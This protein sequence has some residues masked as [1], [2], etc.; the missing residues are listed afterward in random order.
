MNKDEVRNPH[1]IYP[2]N[3]LVLDMSGGQPR[4][5]L[6]GTDAG[7]LADASKGTGVGSTAAH[8]ELRGLQRLLG[9]HRGWL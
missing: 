8:D 6:E 2:G 3:V 1:L 5:R 7:G 4:L 9:G